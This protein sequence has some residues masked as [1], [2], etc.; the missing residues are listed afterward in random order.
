[1]AALEKQICEALSQYA[2]R[3]K[4]FDDFVQ[5]FVPISCNIDASADAEAIELAHY[6]DGILAEAS[7]SQW[8][9][10][11]LHEELARPFVAARFAENAFGDPSSFPIPQS[12]AELTTNCAVAA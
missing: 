3:R 11:D 2:S 5:W 10:E 9:E 7:S 8:S 4:S 1:M 6:I 12:S